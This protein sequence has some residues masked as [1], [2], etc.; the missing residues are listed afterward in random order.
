MPDKPR[1][2]EKKREVKKQT[3]PSFRSD[4][5]AA[6]YFD[7]HDT[8]DL[9]ETLPE[10]PGPIIDAR[11]TLK[12]I[13]LRLPSEAIAE[14]KQVAERRG[15]GYQTL[16]RIWIVERLGRERRRVS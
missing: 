12:P 15:V 13:S 8:A 9:A 7:T 16:L 14:A 4:E 3:F 10:V 5:E 11:P 2:K 6:A 1:N